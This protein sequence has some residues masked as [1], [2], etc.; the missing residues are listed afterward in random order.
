M[1]V[2]VHYWDGERVLRQTGN[3]MQDSTSWRGC[4]PGQKSSVGWVC[5]AVAYSRNVKPSNVLQLEEEQDHRLKQAQ[6]SVRRKE[7]KKKKKRGETEKRGAE[8][9]EKDNR[10]ACLCACACACVCACACMCAVQ[11]P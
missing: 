6:G 10:S 8:G 11:T 5:I 2:G 3:Y 7:E 1:H 9:E 4:G